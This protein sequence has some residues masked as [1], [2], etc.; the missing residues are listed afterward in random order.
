MQTQPFSLSCHNGVTTIERWDVAILGA[1]PADV[2]QALVTAS[3]YAASQKEHGS[4]ERAALI[5]NDTLPNT[6]RVQAVLQDE[7]ACANF[8]TL[9]GLN[10]TTI[11]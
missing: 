11:A 8:L 7:E 5:I 9:L 3:A 4:A 10:P 1:Q 6:K 2:A